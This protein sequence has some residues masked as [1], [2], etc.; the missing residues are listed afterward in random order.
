MENRRAGH[1]S[2]GGSLFSLPP[3][4]SPPSDLR[5]T[6]Q[7]G[8]YPFA[9]LLSKELLRFLLFLPAVLGQIGNSRI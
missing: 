5:S 2:G 8:R 7:D 9:G 4:I 3:I 1:C 6:A